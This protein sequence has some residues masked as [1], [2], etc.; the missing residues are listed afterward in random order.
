MLINSLY[1]SPF[2]EQYLGGVQ[3]DS[4]SSKPSRL[5]FHTRVF[6][7]PETNSNTVFQRQHTYTPWNL[8]YS[9]HRSSSLHR[10]Y[11]CHIG[12]VVWSQ[13][14]FTI[15]SVFDWTAKRNE[16]LQTILKICTNRSYKRFLASVITAL[17]AEGCSHE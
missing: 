17:P 11:I 10:I 9:N 14:L 7:V 2:I 3:L 4:G 5:P 8:S 6:W 1:L 15:V 16:T 12:W 13:V